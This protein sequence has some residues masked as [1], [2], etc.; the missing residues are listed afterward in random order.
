VRPGDRKDLGDNLTRDTAA[1]GPA[2][3]PDPAPICLRDNECSQQQLV[4]LVG[5]RGPM[6]ASTSW[7]NLRR[8]Q[9]ALQ[10]S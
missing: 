1:Q 6:V 8:Q 5:Y 7:D 3:V 10:A 9:A 4:R 2:L